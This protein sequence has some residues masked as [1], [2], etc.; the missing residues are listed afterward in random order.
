MQTIYLA[1][2]PVNELVLKKSNFVKKGNAK[3][4][5]PLRNH[6]QQDEP[7]RHGRNSASVAI[8]QQFGTLKTPRSWPEKRLEFPRKAAIVRGQSRMLPKH[9]SCVA[10]TLRSPSPVNALPLVRT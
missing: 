10:E 5:Q 8:R 2:N 9:H 7:N 3:H 1:F 6:L 4:K